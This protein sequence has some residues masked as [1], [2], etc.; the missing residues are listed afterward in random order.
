M[1]MYMYVVNM[2]NNSPLLHVHVGTH[3]IHTIS[4]TSPSPGEVR[5]TGNLIDGSATIGILIII[6]SLTDDSTTH[7]DFVPHEAEGLGVYAT[8]MLRGLP[9]GQYE[10]SVY[11]MEESGLPFHRAAATL[12]LIH[13]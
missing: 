7:Y 6:Y 9:G 13:I 10:I 2:K 11:V 1:Y 4:A 5:V 12:S 8:C 3:D